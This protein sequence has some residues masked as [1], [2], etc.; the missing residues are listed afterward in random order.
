MNNTKLIVTTIILTGATFI[1]TFTFAKQSNFKPANDWKFWSWHVIWSGQN[2][3]F[4]KKDNK[5][6]N[7]FINYDTLT[8]TQKTSLKNTFAELNEKIK[9]LR[10]SILEDESNKESIEQEIQDTWKTYMTTIKSY[11]SEDKLTEFETFITNWFK[12]WQGQ[13]REIKKQNSSKN[14]TWNNEEIK[15]SEISK[16][17]KYFKWASYTNIK[18]K[19]DK[20]T[21]EKLTSIYTKIKSMINDLN[22]NDSQIK[23][24][25]TKLWIYWE[26]KN[27]LEDKLGNNENSEETEL[28]NSLI[29][30]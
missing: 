27:I 24:K 14:I 9:T 10:D 11:V 8:D 29:Q 2:T 26:F 20:L 16:N 23:N 22:N 15:Q 7:N 4:E 25:E 19:L 28:L 12:N 13:N 18:N 3:N 30:E 17:Y 5:M 21:N 6:L 1:T